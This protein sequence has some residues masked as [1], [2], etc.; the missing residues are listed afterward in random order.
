MTDCPSSIA[1]NATDTTKYVS[2]TEPSFI[3]PF[4]NDLDITNNYPSPSY[5]F[6]WGDF[7]VQYTATKLNNGLQQECVFN[8]SVRRKLSYVL[9]SLLLLV[10]MQFIQHCT[11]TIL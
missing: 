2:W 10:I 11:N 4:G 5:D 3:D 9:Y 7:T 6:P 8:I 1:V